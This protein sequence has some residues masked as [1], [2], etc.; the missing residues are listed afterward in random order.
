MLQEKIKQDL[1]KAIL[2]RDLGKKE[3]LRVLLGELD[4]YGKV[5]DDNVTLTVIK[6][7]HQ[8]AK[9]M[10]EN[11]EAVILNEYLPKMLNNDELYILIEDLIDKGINNIG[12][13]MKEL[14][15]NY[16]GLYDGKRASEIIKELL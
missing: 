6:K 12:A 1:K 2:N 5:I 7:M 13:I 15:S 11:T 16:N 3:I 10:N 14:K 9:D 4:R 8:N